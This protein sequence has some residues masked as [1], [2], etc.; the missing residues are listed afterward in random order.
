MSVKVLITDP[1]KCTGCRQCQIACA[2]SR[3]G[4]SNPIKS[5]I[6]IFPVIGHARFLPVVCQHCEDAPCMTACPRE[7]IHREIET[8]RIMV[9]YEICISCKMCVAACPFGAIA[10]DTGGQRVFKCD[11]CGGDPQCVPFCY[12]QALRFEEPDRG[13][14]S[15]IREAALRQAGQRR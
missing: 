4:V 8:N 3:F 14:Y 13:P 6:R 12:P 7:A 5:R 10:F 2:L 15:R 9:D 11:F 1:Q